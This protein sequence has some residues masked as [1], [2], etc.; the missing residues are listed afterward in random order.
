MPTTEKKITIQI[1]ETQNSGRVH[2]VAHSEIITNGIPADEF[3]NKINADLLAVS[4]TISSPAGQPEK[5]K[6]LVWGNVFISVTAGDYNY[7]VVNDGTQD[8][9]CSDMSDFI[10]KIEN[11][12]SA[13]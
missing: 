13:I 6:I 8:F 3:I 12:L 9:N 10:D 4:N 11:I 7:L 5:V 2:I 1:T